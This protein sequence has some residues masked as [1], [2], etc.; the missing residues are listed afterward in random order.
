MIHRGRVEAHALVLATPVIGEE[1]ARA[2]VLELWSPGL[3][4]R[5]LPYGHWLLVLPE[6]V[7]V[8]AEQAPGLPLTDGVH[9][10]RID[11][12]HAGEVRS[13]DLAALPA[14]DPAQWLELGAYE[15]RA[16]TPL[17]PP[18]PLPVAVLPPAADEAAPDLRA[19]AGVQGVSARAARQLR[20]AGQ[21]SQPAGGGPVHESLLAR[22]AMQSPAAAWIRAR[23]ERYL[24]RLTR[25]FEEG[26]WDDALRDAV[27]LGGGPDGG[28]TTLRLPGHRTGPL[29]PTGVRAPGGG[30][31]PYGADAQHHLRQLY[32]QAAQALEKEG[33]I[34]EAAFVLADLLDEAEE[35][36]ALLERHGRLRLAAELAEGRAL[37]PAL[38]VRLW[39]RAGDRQRAL[40]VA[41]ARG[42][43]AAAVERLGPV[44]HEA[45]VELRLMWS[46]ELYAAGD[47][48]GSVEVAWAE[49]ELRPGAV[50]LARRAL[51]GN[52]P[53]RAALLAYALARS[54]DPAHL[55]EARALLALP[56]PDEADW[57]EQR[58]FTRTLC[59]ARP[60]AASVERELSTSAL[61]ALVRGVVHETDQKEQARLV[62][63][64]HRRAD[65]LFAADMVTPEVPAGTRP[66]LHLRAER[67]PGR[68]PLTD[69]VALSPGVLLTAHGDAGVRLLGRDGR[70]RARW[71]VPAHRLVVADHGGSAL[72]VAERGDVR[73]IHRLDLATRQVRRWTTLRARATASSYDGTVLAVVDEDGIGF[74]ETRAEQPRARWRELDRDHTVLRLA[75]TPESLAAVLEVPPAVA[76]G[77]RTRE[78]WQWE[79]PSVTLRGRTPVPDGEDALLAGGVALRP[80]RD[81]LGLKLR[82]Y[83]TRKSAQDLYALPSDTVELLTDGDTL[84][85]VVAEEADRRVWFA[86]EP[87]GR[88][89]AGVTFSEGAALG[90]RT[91]GGLITVYDAEGRIVVLDEARRTVVLSARS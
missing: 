91:H 54:P 31:I 59:T 8:R 33:R 50:S 60:Q 88:R 11:V 63:A 64:L 43:F 10:G 20:G 74:V 66:V 17:Q 86:E 7:S 78:V 12:E 18:E 13:Y 29:M 16:L 73:D 41:R 81:E 35:A 79:L 2:R 39:W 76:G 42:A 55:D 90:L 28:A 80:E 56:Q 69:A 34:E 44:D 53:H 19:T 38:V 85:T 67:A 5:E 83:A 72:L 70:V 1:E 52:P 49:R 47:L 24:R 62:R 25:Q 87:G 37:D 26:S 6:S 21:G 30:V 3:E 68:L 32:R 4:V 46:A 89:W 84:A 40:R 58:A 9:A 61:R 71:D 15:V 27:A 45:A 22:W 36:A 23:H 65:P 77:P 14:L 51:D 82:A 57:R 48:L 75:R